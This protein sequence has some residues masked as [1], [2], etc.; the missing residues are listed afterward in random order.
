MPAPEKRPTVCIQIPLGS[1]SRPKIQRSPDAPKATGPIERRPSAVIRKLEM[2][3]ATPV[4]R[5]LF[6]SLYDGA[7]ITDGEGVITD[8]NARAS[9]LLLFS[10][11]ELCG[12]KVT[13]VV[14]GANEQVLA[15]IRQNLDNLR[16]TSIEAYCLRKDGS[17]F[18]AEI[19][20][21]RLPGEKYPHLCFFIRDVTRRKNVE[22]E[23]RQSNES[24]LDL[25]RKLQENQLQ[26]IQSEKM[27]ALGQI[28]AGVAHEIN[29]PIGF[30][31]SNLNTLV[32]YVRAIEE[33][34]AEYRKLSELHAEDPAS[35]ELLKSISEIAAREN[36]PFVLNDIHSLLSESIE[37]VQRTRDIV[38]NLKTFARLDEAE[39]KEADLNE[40]IESTLKIVW[41]ELR[42]KCEIHK[43]LSP[44]PPIQCHPGQLN[45]VF[46]NLFLNAAQS[47]QNKGVIRVQSFV[48][49]SNIVIKISDNGTGIP[50][51]NLSKLFTPFFTTKPVGKG[52]GL[53][54]SISYGII[55]K[56]GGTIEVETEEGK[57][58]CFTIKLPLFN[59][60]GSPS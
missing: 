24:L 51:E 54:L 41:N 22:S 46:M 15:E 57:G 8:L 56:H 1:T 26:L 31:T 49:K 43:D 55:Q 13:Q 50:K 29:N 20:V 33:L 17:C 21:N 44:L 39:C 5:G 34:L 2:G 6:Q 4:Y 38:Q 60:Q 23:L 58:T 53:G 10:A 32:E 37:G 19:V 59:K 12:V 52:T 7:L 25:N 9:D 42:Y 35:R 27:A 30:I 47:I 18:P 40:A 28:A 14:S 45:Q 36:I 16:F 11:A 48:E 3:I